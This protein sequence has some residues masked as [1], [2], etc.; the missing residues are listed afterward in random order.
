MT[1]YLFAI[2]DCTINQAIVCRARAGE[3]R[4]KLTLIYSRVI[5]QIIIR[6]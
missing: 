5:N 1:K 6:A 3:R 2:N 4:P